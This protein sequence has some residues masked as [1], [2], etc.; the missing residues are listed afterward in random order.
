MTGSKWDITINKI[1]GKPS[2][3]GKGGA[4]ICVPQAWLKKTVFVVTK[5]TWE[6]L[7]K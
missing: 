6:E 5:D 2:K 7:Q 4:H 3:F 1:E